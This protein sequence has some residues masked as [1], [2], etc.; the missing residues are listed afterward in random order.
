[1]IVGLPGTG[2]GG[3]YYLFSAL[4]MPVCEAWRAATGRRGPSRW[5]GVAKLAALALGIF[6]GL[7]ATAVAL[8][9]FF[10]APEPQRGAVGAPIEPASS[11]LGVTATYVTLATLATLL[12][13]VEAAAAVMRFKRG[14]R[15][16]FGAD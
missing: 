4:L 10:P 16:A 12:V 15:Q 11:S 8:D 6:G 3:L 7:F 14:R 13:T 5:V 1:M 9:Y 2:I